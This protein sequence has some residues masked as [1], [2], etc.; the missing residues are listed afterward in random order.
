MIIEQIYCDNSLRNF[1][2]IIACDDTK[3]ALVID[4]LNT[5]DIIK[6][7][8][9][10][11]YNI[12][13]IINTHDHAD[14]TDGNL[15]L[16]NYY[17][18]EIFCHHNA[19]NNIPGA[20]G[21]SS[22]YKNNIIK[23]GNNIKIKVLDTPGHTMAHVCLLA[24]QQEGEYSLFS[25]DTLFNAGAG[26]CYSGSVDSMYETFTN[27]LDKLPDNTVVYPGH[28]YIENNLNFTLSREPD[29]NYAK[30][31]LKEVKSLEHSKFMLTTMGIEKQINTFF[32]LE[33]KNI[34]NKLVADQ[35]LESS[36][37]KN[38]FNYSDKEI[39]V[40]LRSLRNTW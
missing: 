22:L 23:I 3:E 18:A 40:A 1:N 37:N 16:I 31:L 14:H 11:N 21:K 27:I 2:Y 9:D 10:K 15:E 13:K 34:I 28:D 32:R 30:K 35:A 19:I 8:Q 25:G 5:K 24:Y 29:N 26:N 12:T 17:N 4:P 33:N 38:N 6:L 20:T 36:S 39:F 7:A